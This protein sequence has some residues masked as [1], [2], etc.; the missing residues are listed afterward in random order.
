MT[1]TEITSDVYRNYIKQ[2]VVRIGPWKE[3]VVQVHPYTY[4]NENEFLHLN[5]SQD[6]D[7]EYEYWINE[8]GIDGLF[9]D[10]TGSLHNY[11]E[12]TSPL[13]ET[14]KSPRQLLGQIVSLV[15]PYAKA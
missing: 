8:I 9:T 15:I 1:Y 4:R 5:F 11:Q 14:S 6:P 7:K 10:F 2:Y 13:S 3:T 12:W